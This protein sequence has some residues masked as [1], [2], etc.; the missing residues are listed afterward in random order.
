MPSP[1]D[2]PEMKCPLQGELFVKGT[3]LAKLSG[4]LDTLLA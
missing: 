3:M 2:E 4:S 1:E